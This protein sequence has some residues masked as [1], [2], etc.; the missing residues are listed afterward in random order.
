MC[1]PGEQCTGLM[2]IKN[3]SVAGEGDRGVGEARKRRQ[4]GC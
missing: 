3:D 4:R 1:V 2:P